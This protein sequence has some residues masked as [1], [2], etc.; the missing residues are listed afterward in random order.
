MPYLK[1]FEAFLFLL[2]QIILFYVS[3]SVGE[4]P[5]SGVV[6]LRVCVL[7]IFIDTAKLPF[8]QQYIGWLV[9]IWHFLPAWHGLWINKPGTQKLN[10]IYGKGHSWLEGDRGLSSDHCKHWFL[11][12]GVVLRGY[13]FPGFLLG[14]IWSLILLLS[15]LEWELYTCVLLGDGTYILWK[16]C[17]LSF[18]RPPWSEYCNKMSHNVFA[19]GGSCLQFVKKK[20]VVSM[21][22]NNVKCNKTR[23]A[24]SQ[25]GAFLVM[26]DNVSQLVEVVRHGPSLLKRLQCLLLS[27]SVNWESMS[28]GTMYEW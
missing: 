3:L 9:S 15:T 11:T 16:Y 21:K 17:G 24:C 25:V 2:Q 26:L 10:L 19:G 7:I 8:H 13:V 6:G 4:M 20:S 22:Y 5:S 27:G 1:L 12:L 28:F 14:L 23:Y 18:R